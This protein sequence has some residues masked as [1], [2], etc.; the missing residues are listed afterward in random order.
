[1][2]GISG[3]IPVAFAP[4]GRTLIVRP[5]AGGLP[6]PLEQLHMASGRL[7]P[8]LTLAPRD[9]VGVGSL[10]TIVVSR[11]GRVVVANYARRLS[12]LYLVDAGLLRR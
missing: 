3:F 8:W 10:G 6:L 9:R 1:V 2:P 7:E 5:R 11:D 4:S 12:E